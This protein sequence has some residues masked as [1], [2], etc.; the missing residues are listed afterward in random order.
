MKGNGA[1]KIKKG[2]PG[3]EFKRNRRY[4]WHAMEAVDLE[5]M[6]TRTFAMKDIHS[7]RPLND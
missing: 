7:W 2:V 3:P 4:P 5:T 6:S 1:I